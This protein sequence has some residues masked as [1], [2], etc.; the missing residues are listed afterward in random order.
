MRIDLIMRRY[1]ILILGVMMLSPPVMAQSRVSEKVWVLPFQIYASD[2]M[3]Y[4]SSEI[5]KALEVKLKSDGATIV[6]SKDFPQGWGVNE[7]IDP[8]KIRGVGR[9]AGADFVL[10]GSLTWINEQYSI[11]ASLINTA[12]EDPPRSHYVANKGVETVPATV[13]ELSRDLGFTIFKREKV[14]EVK[15]IGNQRIEVDAIRKNIQT[16]PGDVFLSKSLSEDLKRIYTMGYFED[17]RI[18]AEEG[19]AGKTVIFKVTEKPIVRNIKFKGNRV[20]DDEELMGT[21]DIKT[22]AVLNIFS[23]QR[24]IS[25]LEDQYKEK[26]YQNVKI[27]YLVETVEQNRG[28]L[29][30]AITEGEKVRIKSIE[31]EGNEAY[32]GDD[33]KDEMKTSEKGFFSWLTSSGDLS[34]EDLEQDVAKLTAFYQNNG[35][36]Q[37][38]VGEPKITFEGEWIYIK[39]KVYEGSRF[40]V[41]NV[42]LKGDLIMPVDQLKKKLEISEESFFNRQILR[43]DIVTLT[44]LYSDEG[45]AYA[46]MIPKLDQDLENKVVHIDI[47]I[48]KGA[49]VYFERILIS[50]NTR[51]RDKVIRRQLEV[52]EGELFSG[53]KLKRGMRNLHRIGY[54]EDVQA[55]T[56]KGS[57]DDRMILDVEVKEKSTGTFSVG[58]GYS[59]VENFFVTGAIQ[60]RNLF[61]HGL[62][63][64]LKGNIGD[65]TKRFN[66]DLIEPWLFDIPLSAGVGVYKWNYD[67]DN[68]EKDSTGG[69]LRAGYP[70]FDDTRFFLKYYYDI[71]DVDNIDEDAAKS[72]KELEGKNVTSAVTGTIRYDS[73]NRYFYTTS[74]QDHRVNAEYAGIGG[75]INFIKYTGEL[76]IYFPLL[77]GLVGFLHTEGGYV[78]EHS[79]GLLPDYQK[80][81]MGGIH[82]LRGFDWREV[83]AT[84]EDGDEIGGNTYV[85]FNAEIHIPILKDQGI[86]GVLFYDTGNVFGEEESVDLGNLRQ[87]AGYGIR[88]NSP[89]GPIRLER[90]HILDPEGDEDSGGRWEFAM[91]ASF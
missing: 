12:T 64:D 38:R 41:G 23:I 83:T 24:N 61:G 69:S 58:G 91:E 70:I 85:Q 89:V 60:E 3:A 17:V 62:T 25:R 44:D 2:D 77:K 22:G 5:K 37:A 48:K 30:F 52:N 73:R 50:G 71:A 68:Y 29:T 65:K 39:I 11:D 79:N 33:L 9:Q 53:D 32:S 90:G 81:Y 57:A 82:S 18:E 6:S 13:A 74:G 55:N 47:R 75:D 88:W 78:T 51:T 80:F 27:E 19:P 7:K 26:N 72:I 8:E 14:A 4:L 20:F 36:I 76:G 66:L 63:L 42:S 87:T 56:R 45:Y 31:F 15:I 28:D 86:L 54:F 35:Y 46:D 10:W 34:K 67:Y 1:F 49:P 59:S 43:N 84:D 40:R 21:L 16:R